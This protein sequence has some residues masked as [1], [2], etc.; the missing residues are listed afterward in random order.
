MLPVQV[1]HVAIAR[2]FSTVATF[3][4]AALNMN[5]WASGLGHSLRQESG[6]WRADGPE[7]P[8][9][10]RFS[11]PNAFGIADHWVEVTPGVELY[12]PLR[13]IANGEGC[14]VQLTLF[15]PPGMSDGKF[16]ED[17]AW[18]KRDLET[19]KTLLETP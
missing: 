10:I 3:L 8:V 15:R 11:P 18:V 16:A 4:A 19:L 9:R 6:E 12:I 1:I 13:A 2:P 17:A 5:H 7:G 14:E